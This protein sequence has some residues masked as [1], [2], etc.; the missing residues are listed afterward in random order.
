MEI[1]KTHSIKQSDIK[2]KWVIVDAADQTLGRLATEV[3]RVL[4]GKHKPTFTPHLDTGDNV[5]VIN[6][7][8]VKMT[9]T[10]LTDK[11]YHHHT[12]Y[13]GGIKQKSAGLILET[14]PE[15]LVT[16]AVRGMLPKNKLGRGINTNLRVYADDKHGHEGQKPEAMALRTKKS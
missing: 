5:I 11:F 15:R 13:I 10:K 4:R 3:A 9:G 7:A 2:K 12:G 6:A 14:N 16:A 1:M 8:K